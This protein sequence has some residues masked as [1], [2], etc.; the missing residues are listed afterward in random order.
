MEGVAAFTEVTIVADRA[1]AANARVTWSGGTIIVEA[2]DHTALVREIFDLVPN[3]ITLEGDAGNNEF[4]GNAGNDS[5]RGGGGNDTLDGSVGGNDTLDGGEGDDTL[6]A[7]AG[8]DSLTGGGGNDELTGGSDADTFAFAAAHGSD[9]ITDFN[10]REDTIILDGAE[11]AADI[12]VANDGSDV[13]VTWSG[14]TI[15][16]RDEELADITAASFDLTEGDLSRVL[17]GTENAEILAGGDAADTISGLDGND[18]LDGGAGR[19]S[20]DGGSGDDRI[21][22]GADNDTLSGGGGTDTFVFATGYGEDRITDFDAEMDRISLA[23]AAD[24]ADVILA[25]NGADIEVRWSGGTITLEGEDHDGVSAADFVGLSGVVRRVLTGTDGVN[26]VLTGGDGNDTISGLGGSDQLAGGGGADTFLFAAAH[27]SDTIT[28]FDD[29]ADIISLDGVGDASDV[30]VANDGSDVRVTWSGGTITLAG[31]THSDITAADFGLATGAVSRDLTGTENDDTLTGGGGADTISGLGGG[32]ELSGGGGADRLIG[33]PSNDRLTGGGGA[34]TFVFL[35]GHGND[36]IS[37]FDDR[38]DTISLNGVAD[39]ADVTVANHGGDVRVMWSG[40]VIVL[41][42]EAQGSITAA[43]FNLTE[44]AVSRELTGTDDAD[45]LTGGDGADTISGLGGGDELNG[46]AGDDVFVFASGHGSDTIADFMEGSDTISLTGVEDAAG[47]TIANAGGDVVATWSG[48]TI[49]V[50]E[51]LHGGIT[52]ADFGLT[53][54]AVRRNLIGTENAETLTGGDEADTISGLGGNDTLDGGAGNDS[55]SGGGGEDAF[56]FASGHGRDT[57]IDFDAGE[58]RISLDGTGEAADVTIVNSGVDVEVRWSGG[59]IVLASEEHGDITASNFAGPVGTISRELIGSDNPEMLTG[60]AGSDRLSGLAGNDTLRGLGGNDTL[61]GGTG[62]DRL[63]GGAG[64]DVLTGG[65]GADVFVFNEFNGD[66]ITDFDDGSDKILLQGGVVFSEDVVVAASDAGAVVAWMGGQ[67]TLDGIAARDVTVA[68]FIIAGIELIGDSSPESLR[69]ADGNDTLRGGGGADSIYGGDGED[70]ASYEGSSAAV[71]VSLADGTGTAGDAM[72]DTLESIE[73]LIGSDRD[74]T[75]RGDSRANAIEGGEGADMI[76]GGDGEDT[77]SYAGSRTGVNVD[78]GAN[79]MSGGDAEDAMGNTDTLIGIENLE[80]SSNPD[81]LTGD[82]RDNVLLGRMGNDSLSGGGGGDEILGGGGADTL[83]GG[84]GR[85]ILFGWRGNDVLY[86]GA[87]ADMLTGGAGADRLLGGSGDDT[88]IGQ[89]GNDRLDGGVGNDLLGGGADDDSLIGGDGDDT[90]S[91]GGSNDTLDGG[92]GRDILRGGAGNDSLAGGDGN[93]WLTGNEGSDTLAGGAGAD[94]LD[95]AGRRKGDTLDGADTASY[96]G[97][98]Q[99]V[100]VDLVIGVGAGGHAAGDRL[101]GI[102]NLI[103]SDHADTLIGD[104]NANRLYGGAGSDILT[105]R[106]GADMFVF[107]AF[108]GDVISDF[109]N[110]DKISIAA[111]GVIFSDLA[112]ADAGRD[113]AVAW[114]GGTLTLIGV[115]HAAVTEDDFIFG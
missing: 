54:G 74:D 63:S 108:E 35:A 7:S 55:L 27:G 102:E 110:V 31:E 65:D 85:D 62:R 90:L 107:T 1:N 87:D 64:S 100:N 17:T 97:S 16:L 80:G 9:T 99:G 66:M 103:G 20:L 109:T 92:S 11:E 14:G 75:L 46:G 72:G 13:R 79:T 21:T 5:F 73:N 45:T 34:D 83:D 77:A 2:T 38:T 10:D 61:L 41:A 67:L 86:G 49:I 78:L 71:A 22:G 43:D 40:G 60:G 3:G 70:A 50:A 58:D 96:A 32:D 94:F 8:A 95:G 114:N 84:D 15:T 51:E 44:G 26:D 6:V 93:D 105:G 4:I 88:L 18:T 82:D 23:G 33:G 91:G 24:A 69:G 42:S 57:I 106:G 39:A 28:D 30:T 56:V 112:I 115:D 37:D 19:D 113:A 59:I 36:T 104:E 98:D 101:M 53:E 25:N 76:D 68:D 47:I 12:T 48:G 81:T 89:T 52:A 111:S 29:L